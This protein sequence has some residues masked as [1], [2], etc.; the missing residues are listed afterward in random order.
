MDVLTE[1]PKSETTRDK[2]G[3]ALK[4]I[5]T[6][7][8]AEEA[9]SKLEK[10]P[11]TERMNRYH[12][13]L[14]AIGNSILIQADELR[15]R[16]EHEDR[17]ATRA[18]GEIWALKESLTQTAPQVI[19][20]LITDLN[21]D[22]ADLPKKIA[23]GESQRNQ[24]EKDREV[25]QTLR[26]QKSDAYTL[27]SGKMTELNQKRKELQTHQADI[28]IASQ[29]L[30]KISDRVKAVLS[31]STPNPSN[32]LQQITT[33]VE[34][35]LKQY[36]AKDPSE[37]PKQLKVLQEYLGSY[38][39]VIEGRIK[40]YTDTESFLSKVSAAIREHKADVSKDLQKRDSE[41]YQH[42][43]VLTT[44]VE[45]KA[46]SEKRLNEIV[47][48]VVALASEKAQLE[49]DQ[50]ITALALQKVLDLRPNIITDIAGLSDSGAQIFTLLINRIGEQRRDPQGNRTTD[51]D[52]LDKVITLLDEKTPKDDPGLAERLAQKGGAICKG[53]FDDTPGCK[54][55]K[56]L[57]DDLIGLLRHEYIQAV[58]TTGKEGRQAEKLQSAMKAAWDLRSDMVYIRPSGS[59]LRSSFPSTSLQDDPALASENLLAEKA[60]L[61]MP[62]D[63]PLRLICQF[64]LPKSAESICK[65]DDYSKHRAQ[66]ALDK[67]F[68]QNINRVRLTGGGWTNY[69]VAKDD[70]GNWYV[71]EVATDP[72]DIIRAAKKLALFGLGTAGATALASAVSQK[73]TDGE[74]SPTDQPMPPLQ[75]VYAKYRDAYE[76]A[77]SE[78]V[79]QVKKILG[80][81]GI[82]KTIQLS[83][84]GN[85]LLKDRLGDLNAALSHAATQLDDAKNVLVNKKDDT[86]RPLHVVNALKSIVRFH[87]DLQSAIQT[88]EIA[89]K[90]KEAVAIAK[91]DFEKVDAS[92]QNE[93]KKA[94][95]KVEAEE[96]A[97]K[98]KQ[99]AAA[100]ASKA[101]RDT[102][103]E[104]LA[105]Q[106]KNSQVANK[107]YEQ[108]L[109]FIGEVRAGGSKK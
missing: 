4:S 101:V 83:W 26:D 2:I 84:E 9:S 94:A 36:P 46:D 52:K 13:V 20:G 31:I 37:W 43:S 25:A 41:V 32:D 54:T 69:V 73:T 70:I 7:S 62:F 88:M 86:E 67:Q 44:S 105:R 93:K 30:N 74:S 35:E 61:H 77:N 59:Y 96:A 72:K 10:S 87:N 45:G 11:S 103:F 58:K 65:D 1:L 64:A 14:Q 108:S 63:M 95:E 109:M 104:T 106:L 97:L 79:N 53:Y 16:R 75:Q 68:W 42:Q 51:A 40:T 29:T 50:L 6:S 91:R 48:T 78:A 90:E 3:F 92:Q 27:A 15:A 82:R 49:N 80:S 5:I 107:E 38:G 57:L 33:W 28:E 55:S 85:P 56:E 18:E 19:S 89:A 39:K 47:A 99:D 17:L 71:K 21:A 12:S 24:A 22:L 98:T 100:S 66:S 34:N 76:S 102:C 8:E 23:S 60:L 81:D